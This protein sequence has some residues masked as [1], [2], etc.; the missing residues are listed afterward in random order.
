MQ[1][2]R[3][4]LDESN[5]NNPGAG[6][7]PQ[8]DH[9]V[10]PVLPGTSIDLDECGAALSAGDY[11]AARVQ[12]PTGVVIGEMD[13]LDRPLQGNTGR[14]IEHKAVGEKRCIERCK[15]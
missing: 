4:L 2:F 8:L 10:A 7:N 14:D 15:R 5:R 9:I 1:R 3:T 6:C 13:D 11:E 12:R